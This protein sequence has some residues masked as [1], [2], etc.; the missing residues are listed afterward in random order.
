MAE[1]KEGER[2]TCCEFCCHERSHNECDGS[3]MEIVKIRKPE[4]RDKGK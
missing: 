1:V 4:V 2:E 3:G